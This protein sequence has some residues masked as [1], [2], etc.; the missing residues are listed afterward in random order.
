MFESLFGELLKDLGINE[1]QFV[2]AC[3][4]ADKREENKK[5]SSQILSVDDFLY[6]KKMMQA[7][8]KELNE[9]AIKYLKIEAT[10][11]EYFKRK[12]N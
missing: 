2:N 9:Q 6:F 10:R 11:I 4:M 1:E 12:D 3:E 8:N 5:Y 7:R